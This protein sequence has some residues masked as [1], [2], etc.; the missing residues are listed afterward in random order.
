MAFQPA[1]PLGH[2]FIERR[3]RKVDRHALDRSTAIR[4]ERSQGKLKASY[5]GIVSDTKDCG[6]FGHAP[7]VEEFAILAIWL[8]FSDHFSRASRFSS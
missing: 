4:A 7:V 6:E 8:S 2:A 3:Y 5:P 1:H